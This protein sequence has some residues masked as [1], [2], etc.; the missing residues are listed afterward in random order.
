MCISSCHQALKIYIRP[1]RPITLLTS[2]INDQESISLQKSDQRL[3][4]VGLQ[5]ALGWLTS[6]PY[7]CLVL[8][9]KPSFDSKNFLVRSINIEQYK[10]YFSKKINPITV[11]DVIS[12]VALL[13]VF[14]VFYLEGFYISIIFIIFLMLK[15][16]ALEKCTICAL[17]DY[18]VQM[19]WMSNSESL[20]F[21]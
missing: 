1:Q 8:Y 20:L 12:A 7:M 21:L 11:E 2:M 13:S 14:H 17:S 5:G 3:S 16:N 15:I 6:R 18:L 19:E 9:L 10:L 4:Y